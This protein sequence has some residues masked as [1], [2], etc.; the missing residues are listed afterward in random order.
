MFPRVGNLKK[1]PV[2]SWASWSPCPFQISCCC[3]Q[4][5][6][7]L[8]SNSTE[9]CLGSIRN[10]LQS[11]HLGHEK[12]WRI[13]GKKIILKKKKKTVEDLP[14]VLFSIQVL[15]GSE[16]AFVPWKFTSFLKKNPSLLWKYHPFPM[17]PSWRWRTLARLNVNFLGLFKWCVRQKRLEQ[18]EFLKIPPK[19][20]RGAIT[21][22]WGTW[23]RCVLGSLSM[24]KMHPG[25][26][27]ACRHG[28]QGWAEGWLRAQ[29]SVLMKHEV[30]R[31]Q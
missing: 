15:L 7:L 16:Q 9:Q 17:N 5:V 2:K 29:R 21:C 25:L 19:T 13:T 30:E 10:S 20:T 3:E 28:E 22:M 27:G 23:S 11:K 18:W 12:K 1:I 6:V 8:T 26:P 31:D 4:A 14:S 24:P